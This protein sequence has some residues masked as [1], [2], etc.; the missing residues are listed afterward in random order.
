MAYCAKK[1]VHTHKNISESNILL[2][3]VPDGVI[4]HARLHH[5]S[6]LLRHRHIVAMGLEEGM[7]L[8]RLQDRGC[9]NYTP[10]IK[11][12]M[13]RL[14]RSPWS[15]TLPAQRKLDRRTAAISRVAKIQRSPFCWTSGFKSLTAG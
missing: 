11:T 8:R 10:A 2:K 4:D 12:S 13:A 9:Q 7:A 1:R 3:N 6:T 14:I 5:A 15:A